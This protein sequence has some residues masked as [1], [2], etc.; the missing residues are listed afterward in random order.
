MAL[1][2]R[3][4]FVP[5]TTPFAPNG[6]LDR[7]G[8]ELNVRSH[9]QHG[10]RGVV[11]GGSTG[12]AA[13]LDEREREQMIEW[14]RPL[15]TGERLLV[16]GVGA[17][18]TRAT[19]RNAERA[20]AAGADVVLVVAPHYFGSNMTDDALRTHYLRVADESAQPDYEQDDEP[21]KLH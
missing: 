4:I 12:E 18:S 21:S 14:T 8:L 16:A 9:L 5:I 13:L 6:E 11:V 15:V 2:L 10:L 1:S 3:G 20:A 19:L 17:E 7:A